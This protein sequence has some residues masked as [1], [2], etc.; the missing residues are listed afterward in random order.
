MMLADIKINSRLKNKKF[1]SEEKELQPKLKET[2]QSIDEKNLGKGYIEEE[3]QELKCNLRCISEEVFGFL[4]RIHKREWFDA[5]CETDT[6]KNIGAYESILG[7]LTRARRTRDEQ[8]RRGDNKICRRK[9]IYQWKKIYD[10]FKGQI[11][12]N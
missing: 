10:I 2:L 4:S 11:V 1:Q 9:E 5:D 8:L 3:W 6:G 7:R 12:M